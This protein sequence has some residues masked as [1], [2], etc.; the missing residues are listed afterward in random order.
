MSAAEEKQ[1]GTYKCNR[2]YVGGVRLA[3]G[4]VFAARCGGNIRITDIC[5]C[6][7]FEL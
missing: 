2:R 3:Y 1:R 4:C 7:W 5:E 6:L